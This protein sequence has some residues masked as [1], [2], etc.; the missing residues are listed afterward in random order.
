[1]RIIKGLGAMAAALLACAVTTGCSSDGEPEATP[2]ADIQLTPAQKAISQS[3]V[4]FAIDLLKA[5]NSDD[6]NVLVAP[7]S[8]SAVLSMLANGSGEATSSEIIDALHLSASDASDINEYYKTVTSGLLKADNRTKLTFANAV[9]IDGS[10]KPSSDFKNACNGYYKA[11]V[12]TADFK[13][14]HTKALQD[15]N[16]WVSKATNGEISAIFDPQDISSQTRFCVVNSGTF[17]GKWKYKFNKDDTKPDNFINYKNRTENVMMMRSEGQMSASLGENA[18]LIEVPYGNGAFVMDIIVP[19]P[20]IGINDYVNNILATDYENLLSSAKIGAYVL[21]LPRFSAKI[22]NEMIKALR[23]LG[24]KNAF[25]STADLRPMFDESSAY[26]AK[27]LSIS[28]FKQKI[29]IEV[30]EQGTKVVVVTGSSGRDGK[31]VD[32]CFTIDTPFVYVIRE[33][34]TGTILFIGK[35][36]SLKSMQ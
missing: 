8:A 10:M 15:I 29:N 24:I 21:Y 36:Q 12:G 27:D 4:K 33:V 6:K 7:F 31:V 23:K 19:K 5:S 26:A 20:E 13:G 1:M 22:S 18:D 2:R 35:A 34:S 14:N 28:I 9:W 30:N 32:H 25:T 16:A 17:D 11:N 3:N